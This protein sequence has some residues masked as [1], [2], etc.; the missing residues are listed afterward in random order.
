MEII[1][2]IGGAGCSQAQKL[3]RELKCDMLGV[4]Y[5]DEELKGNNYPHSLCL[6][7]YSKP[8][9]SF[10]PQAVE[11]AALNARE[12]FKEILAG[13]KKITVI[14]GLGGKTGSTAAPVLI[15][16]AHSLG[17]PVVSVVT[18]PFSFEASQR[19]VALPA[20]A[21]LENLCSELHVI[22]YTDKNGISQE[23]SLLEFFDRVSEAIFERVANA[24][25]Q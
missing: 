21:T 14:V 24:E 4:N 17:V 2:G 3:S 13:A 22:D 25:E 18:L 6:E 11:A 19:E 7:Q 23:G 8:G 12:D 20:L 5:S 15:D 10:S 16:A 9:L 1:V